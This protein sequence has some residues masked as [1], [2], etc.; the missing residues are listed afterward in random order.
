MKSQISY[1][2][3]TIYAILLGAPV[4]L[5]MSDSFLRSAHAEAGAWQELYKVRARTVTGTV[6]N[7]R[8]GLPPQN[9]DAQKYLAFVELQ[10]EPDW[11]TYWRNP[12]EAG[13]IPPQFSWQGSSNLK[14]A[15]VLYP[16][17]ERLPDPIGDTIGYKKQV[18]F[19]IEVVPQ[20]SSQPVKLK[21]DLKFGICKDIC[22]PS[23]AAFSAVLPSGIAQTLPASFS[24]ALNSVPR[25]FKRR[26]DGDPF[27]V[28]VSDA[29]KTGAMW[30][31]KFKTE[32]QDALSDQADMFLE[33]PEGLF[34]PIPKKLAES[35][36]QGAQFEITLSDSEYTDLRGKRLVA[37]VVD[38]NGASTKAFVLE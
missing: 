6:T 30:T 2:S 18:I 32:H 24:S 20:D 31:V 12:G 19:P 28:D 23:E 35:P 13:G 38:Q 9:K 4:F 29:H 34:V 26:S 1:F 33:A 36:S 11:K 8:G 15:T 21:I 22:V 3:G 27:L 10:L 17:P 14:S 7:A 16:A 37:T 25:D 5:S